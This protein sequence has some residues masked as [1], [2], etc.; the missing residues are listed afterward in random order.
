MK[1]RLSCFVTFW[2]FV[3]AINF[4]WG[5]DPKA[6]A[7][8]MLTLRAAAE[9]ARTYLQESADVNEKQND[10]VSTMLSKEMLKQVEKFSSKK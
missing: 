6:E 5:A 4:S 10:A 8:R 1:N 9:K 3:G 7:K 2:I